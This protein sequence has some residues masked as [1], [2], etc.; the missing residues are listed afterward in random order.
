L[1]S[2]VILGDAHPGEVDADIVSRVIA[3][4]YD[5]GLEADARAIAVEA[6]VGRSL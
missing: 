4:L 5:V 6:I 3:A 2:L 1:Y